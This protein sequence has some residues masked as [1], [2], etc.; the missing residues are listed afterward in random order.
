MS[1]A[2]MTEMPAI[3]GGKPAKTAPFGR[4]KRYGEEE[5]RELAEALEQG[6]LF[7]AHGKKV[8]ALEEEFAVKNGVRFAVAT[9]SGTT[10]IHAA[11]IALGVGPGD[12]VITAPITDA[13]TVVPILFQGAIPV[14]A[15]LEPTTYNLAPESVEAA[16]TSRT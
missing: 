5:L 10:S 13:G 11:L 3:A 14:F 16:I 1:T 2:T 9:N 15:D 8:R 12:E 6:S 4:E 7:Y